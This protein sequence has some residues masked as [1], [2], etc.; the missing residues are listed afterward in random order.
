MLAVGILI[1]AIACANSEDLPYVELVQEGDTAAAPELGE[2]SRL[3]LRVAIAAVISPRAT[4]ES[5]GLLLDYLSSHLDRPVE[6]IQ[7]GTYAETNEL[8]RSGAVDLAF[9]CGGAYVEGER[10]FGMQLLVAPQVNG[11]TTYYSYIIVPSIS[12][13]QTI[14]D[15]RDTTFAFSDP[16]SNSG[17]LAP[18]WMLSQMD[19]TADDFFENTTYTYSH[20]NSIQAVADRLVD[21]AAVDSLVYDFLAA[22]SSPLISQIRIIDRLGPY[23][24]PPVVVHP[25]IEPDLR[26][27]LLEILLRMDRDLEGRAALEKLHIERFVEID[28]SAYESLREM[29]ATLRGWDENP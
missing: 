8:V 25:D 15:L 20:D 27:V 7:R 1:F 29:A 22:E 19:E 26:A 3:P 17:H 23:G 11:E 16:L 2:P 21:G 14:D 4:L 9:V 10:N 28:I 6:L 12:Q 24:I 13:A 18:L 5:Y